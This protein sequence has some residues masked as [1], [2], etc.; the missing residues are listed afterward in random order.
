MN[1]GSMGVLVEAMPSVKKALAEVS[2]WALREVDRLNETPKKGMA[3]SGSEDLSSF[4]QCCHVSNVETFQFL[5]YTISYGTIMALVC[6]CAVKKPTK[7]N[8]TQ[9]LRRPELPGR[10]V[11]G[12]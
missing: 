3:N 7:Q 10:V 12:D 2:P 9:V 1:I 5:K 4:E 6:R 11:K 8:K